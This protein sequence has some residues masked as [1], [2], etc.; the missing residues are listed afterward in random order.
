MI[1]LYFDITLRIDETKPDQNT[2]DIFSLSFTQLASHLIPIWFRSANIP[3]THVHVQVSLYPFLNMPFHLPNAHTHL[4]MLFWYKT[5]LCLFWKWPQKPKRLSRKS[6]G[7]N[8]NK[9]RRFEKDYNR[10]A[11]LQLCWINAGRLPY[12]TDCLYVL[13]FDADFGLMSILSYLLLFFEPFQS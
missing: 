12:V 13:L 6:N 4:K 3:I 8:F 7:W 2:N 9:C 5:I 10:K 11:F 1:I